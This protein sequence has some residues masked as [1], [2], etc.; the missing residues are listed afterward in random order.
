M[1]PGGS[2]WSKSLSAPVVVAI[3][4]LGPVGRIR[5]GPG[6][7]G[8]LAGLLY[9]GACFSFLPAAHAW[10]L[11]ILISLPMLWFAVAICGEAEIRLGQRDPGG[12]VLDEFVVMPLC[13]I[14]WQGL[15]PAWTGEARWGLFLAGFVLF[16]IFDIAKPFGISRLQNLSGGLGVVADDVA[17]ALASCAMLHAAGRLAVWAGWL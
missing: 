10:W 13:F 8:S 17:A 16:R 9:F 6:T 7:A 2:H 5:R 1:S 14:G 11:T 12:V 4:T 15:P 3:A